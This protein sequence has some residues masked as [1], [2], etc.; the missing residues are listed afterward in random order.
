MRDEGGFTLI[1]VMVAMAVL[2]LACLAMINL[3]GASIGTLAVTRQAILASIVAENALNAALV[4]SPPPALGRD[5]S[6]VENGGA[7]WR[8]AREVRADAPTGLLRIDVT[9]RGTS[10]S[11]VLTGFRSAS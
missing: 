10:A 9:V 3:N 6:A 1:E 4:A 5:M 11:A 7:Q 8:V 2:S